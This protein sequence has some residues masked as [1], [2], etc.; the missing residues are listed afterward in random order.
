M[1]MLTY[2]QGNPES[3]LSQVTML[4]EQDRLGEVLQKRYPGSH[5]ITTDKA[6]YQYA[7]DMKN[8]Y[9]RHAASVNKVRYDSRVRYPAVANAPCPASVTGVRASVGHALVLSS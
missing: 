3:L 9:L 8:Q 4:I 6:L 2:L 7:V 1:T 5:D